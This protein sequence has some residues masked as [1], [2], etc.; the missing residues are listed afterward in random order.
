MCKRL[1]IIILTE[2]VG[3][4]KHGDRRLKRQ[5][6]RAARKTAALKD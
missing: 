1:G 4:G 3:A 5:K 6:T 2:D